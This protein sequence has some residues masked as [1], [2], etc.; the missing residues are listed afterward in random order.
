MG[1]ELSKIIIAAV[2]FL[3]VSTT[4]YFE[5]TQYDLYVHGKLINK[6][7]TFIALETGLSKINYLQY[8]RV[9]GADIIEGKLLKSLKSFII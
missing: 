5:G 3:A 6:S 8:R 9:C 1:F 4:F 7:S 2:F